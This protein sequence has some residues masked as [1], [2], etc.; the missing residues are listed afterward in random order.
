MYI[1][2]YMCVEVQGDYDRVKKIRDVVK[3]SISQFLI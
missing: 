2:I 3:F 1:Y